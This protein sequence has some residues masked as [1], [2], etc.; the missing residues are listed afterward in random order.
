[1]NASACCN[2]G[3]ILVPVWFEEQERRQ[4]V[5]TGRYRKACSHLQCENCGRSY[6]V[7]DSFDGPWYFKPVCCNLSV[8]TNKYR[9]N[10]TCY[11]TR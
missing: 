5:T 11:L 8:K 9:Q 3:T 7:D 2:C 6:A 4:G 1:M 10:A